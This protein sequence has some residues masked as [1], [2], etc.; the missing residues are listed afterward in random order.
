MGR[1][2][3]IGGLLM[4]VCIAIQCV[5]VAVLLRV[6]LLLETRRVIRPTLAG[7]TGVLIA[8]VLILVAGNLSQIAV[9][10]TCFR[11]G[12]E[13]NDFA[14]AFYHSVVNF[15]TLGYGD[16]VMSE[17]GRLLGA[18]E[19]GNGVLMFGLST[20]VLFVILNVQ[21]QRAWDERVRKGRTTGT[22]AA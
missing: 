14:T 15:T 6:L 17:K 1:T 11:F 2:L 5:V 10:A 16:I 12:G 18:L 21:M 20:S 19:A 9:W 13:F 7:T 22:T 8:V 4:A 3:V